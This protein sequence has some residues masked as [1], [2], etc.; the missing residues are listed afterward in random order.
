MDNNW[1]C[2]LNFS[3]KMNKLFQILSAG[4]F[5]NATQSAFLIFYILLSLFKLFT[6]FIYLIL[7]NFAPFL[8]SKKN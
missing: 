2:F 4:F 1:T 3:E 5:G 7:E 6:S 8:Y